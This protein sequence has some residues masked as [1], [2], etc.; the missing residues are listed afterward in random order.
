MKTLIDVFRQFHKMSED[1]RFS[2][3]VR[4]VGFAIIAYWNEYGR[5]NEFDVYHDRL[6]NASGVNDDEYRLALDSLSKR[7][8]IKRTRTRRR[9]CARFTIEI[10]QDGAKSAST[11]GDYRGEP[12][13]SV[14]P[15]PQEKTQSASAS[16]A[17]KSDVETPIPVEN[18]EDKPVERRLYEASNILVSYQPGTEKYEAT[19]RRYSINYEQLFEYLTEKFPEAFITEELANYLIK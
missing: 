12:V 4:S 16:D 3:Q 14:N 19:L 10:A 7:H 8:I 9:G 18:L 1:G 5:K 17:R 6:K 11:A 15:S 2:A 13:P